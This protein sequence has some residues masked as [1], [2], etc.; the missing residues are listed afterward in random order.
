MGASA[1][2]GRVYNEWKDLFGKKQEAN[3]E[4]KSPFVDNQGFATS[5]NTLLIERALY[6][7]RELGVTDF[8][9]KHRK[10][11][12]KNCSLKKEKRASSAKRAGRSDWF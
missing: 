8:N 6:S 1:R 5:R 11:M 7:H 12:G 3:S 2:A 9:A 10:S 4:G